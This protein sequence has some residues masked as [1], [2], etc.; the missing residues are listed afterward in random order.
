MPN[1]TYTCADLDPGRGDIEADLTQL[2]F[3]DHDFDVVICN[4][5]LEH[6]PEDRKA[7]AEVFRV[8]KPGGW[9]ILQTPFDRSREATFEDS[10]A[11]TPE[12]RK[13]LYGHIDHVR[14][15]GRDFKARLEQAG[16]RVT[17][18]GYVRTLGSSFVARHALP[19]EEDVCLCVKPQ[20]GS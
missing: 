4:H 3:N 6:V 14:I 13:R 5:V 17:F 16:F 12:D 7:M 15:Y 10:S 18:D 9:A 1:L 2:P 19:A 20:D 11:V 8:L